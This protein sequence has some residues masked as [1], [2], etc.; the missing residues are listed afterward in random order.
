M[1]F[2][3]YSTNKKVLGTKCKLNK[4]SVNRI[5]MFLQLTKLLKNSVMGVCGC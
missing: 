5:N 4:V 1:P 2:P 3:I